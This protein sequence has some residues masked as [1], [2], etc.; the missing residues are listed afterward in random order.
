MHSQPTIVADSLVEVYQANNKTMLATPNAFKNHDGAKV[1]DV[2]FHMRY[3]DSLSD[4]VHLRKNS[5][6]FDVLSGLILS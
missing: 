3:L 2:V 1:Q 4:V 6:S 5:A